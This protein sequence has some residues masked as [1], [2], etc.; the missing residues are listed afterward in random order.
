MWHKLAT[1]RNW[2]TET[3]KP[4]FNRPSGSFGLHIHEPQ[5]DVLA[6]GRLVAM[7][8]NEVLAG[9]QGGFA[10]GAQGPRFITGNK[11]GRAQGQHAIK[12]DL[13]VFVVMQPGLQ[14]V[15]VARGHIKFAPQ[16]NVVR[17]PGRADSR[18]GSAG[19]AEATL[20]LLPRRA[21]EARFEP[22]VSRLGG[23]IVAGGRRQTR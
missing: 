17:V 1:Q 15:P 4:G 13:S 19:S 14:V 8:R 5:I 22:S 11:P 10:G 21:V 18:A 12:I 9:P 2:Q 16:P 3:R 6:A 20:P 23:R 7:D